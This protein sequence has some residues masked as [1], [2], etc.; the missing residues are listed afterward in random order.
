GGFWRGR[1]G[2]GGDH[3]GLG[4]GRRGGIFQLL[5]L[6]HGN[7]LRLAILEELEVF[8]FETFDRVAGFVAH[9]TVHDYERAIAGERDG[10][11]LLLLRLLRQCEREGEKESEKDS[12]I[13]AKRFGL[14]HQNR[15]LSVAESVR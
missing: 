2:N 6:E 15:N 4:C 3:L 13:R 9:K 5:K 11:F 1:F 7:V 12:T 8:L 10:F 14:S